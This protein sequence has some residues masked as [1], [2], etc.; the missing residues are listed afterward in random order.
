M[1]KLRFGKAPPASPKD[2]FSQKLEGLFGGAFAHRL[3]AQHQQAGKE[4][5]CRQGHADGRATRCRANCGGRV[6]ARATRS[7][8]TG[9]GRRR[10][11]DPLAGGRAEA[12]PVGSRSAG[13]VARRGGRFGGE[14]PAGAARS[15]AAG[16]GAGRAEGRQA[17]AA[18]SIAAG[19]G[20]AEGRPPGRRPAGRGGAEGRGSGASIRAEGRGSRAE[21]RGSG[22]SIRSSGGGRSSGRGWICR[23]ELG[24]GG[25]RAELGWRRPELE[26]TQPPAVGVGE[27][28]ERVEGKERRGDE[29]GAGTA[30]ARE[31]RPSSLLAC[32]V[33]PSFWSFRGWE[34]QTPFGGAWGFWSF[35]E[36]QKLLEAPPKQGP[37][38]QEV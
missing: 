23:A 8:A 31:A 9:R 2:C 13:R 27:A 16:A 26:R 10:G 32:S 20:H 29:E 19:V 25:R 15:I 4:Q 37:G 38:L 33:K 7:W 3:L 36:K 35:L 28:R 24:G 12:R 17:G 5:S 18:R 6:E 14:Q 21:G 34:N 11:G 30:K 1:E 22:A